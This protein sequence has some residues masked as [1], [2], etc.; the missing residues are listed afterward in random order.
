MSVLLDPIGYMKEK[1]EIGE[2]YWYD[3]SRVWVEMNVWMVPLVALEAAVTL[4]H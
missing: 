1:G 3:V 2:R 4:L